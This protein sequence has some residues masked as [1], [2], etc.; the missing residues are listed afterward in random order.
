[1]NMLPYRV[2]PGPQIPTSGWEGWLVEPLYQARP[3]DCNSFPLLPHCSA[4][5][6]LW[7]GVSSPP[8]STGCP[9]CPWGLG[10]RRQPCVRLGLWEG[11]ACLRHFRLWNSSG[12]APCLYHLWRKA[13]NPWG[14]L[15]PACIQTITEERQRKLEKG[16]RHRSKMVSG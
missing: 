1:M 9:G 15:G 16:A 14:T 10:C 2:Q 5:S 6:L 11:T 8:Q 4:K 3:P 12:P 7:T 13:C